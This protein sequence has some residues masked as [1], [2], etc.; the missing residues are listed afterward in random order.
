LIKKKNFVKTKKNYYKILQNKLRKRR[1]LKVRRIVYV[2]RARLKKKSKKK[3]LDFRRKKKVRFVRNLLKQPQSTKNRGNYPLL[4]HKPRSVPHQVNYKKR[5]KLL[6]YSIFKKT[7]SMKK[8][9][10][11]LKLRKKNLYKYKRRT[12]KKY[13]PLVR[14]KK[15]KFCRKKFNVKNNF[16]KHNDFIFLNTNT[17]IPGFKKKTD[18]GITNRML[19]FNSWANLTIKNVNTCHRFDPEVGESVMSGWCG[20]SKISKTP[21]TI[22]SCFYEKKI[23]FKRPPINLLEM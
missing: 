10:S 18:K 1:F 9:K 7:R 3:K 19:S 13:L 22:I 17:T 11:K 6:L 21:Q 23:N 14:N 20:S 12:H 16:Y 2:H 4:N 5:S 15:K 8:L